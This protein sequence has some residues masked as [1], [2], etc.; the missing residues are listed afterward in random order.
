MFECLVKM[1]SRIPHRWIYRM[2]AGVYFAAA[3]G[4]DKGVV[5]WM[6]AGLYL[7]L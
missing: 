6:L 2:I 5:S 7:L 4:L 1:K 3:M